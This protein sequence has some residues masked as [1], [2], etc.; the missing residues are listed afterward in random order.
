MEFQGYLNGEYSN[1][2]LEEN[3]AITRIL[4][5]PALEVLSDISRCSKPETDLTGRYAELVGHNWPKC[6]NNSWDL[7]ER[8]MDGDHEP[9]VKHVETMGVTAIYYE[10][11]RWSSVEQ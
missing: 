1:Y 10:V 6:R 2:S 4:K 8:E 5:L 9:R 3:L 7:D 11:L